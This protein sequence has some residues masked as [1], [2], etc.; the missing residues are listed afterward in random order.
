MFKTNI[1][2]V[3]QPVK[4]KVEHVQHVDSKKNGALCVGTPERRVHS[5]RIVIAEA[6]QRRF[7]SWADR[8]SRNASRFAICSPHDFPPRI[9]ACGSGFHRIA[10][11]ICSCSLAA[12]VI[13]KIP[14]YLARRLGEL[15]CS[16]CGLHFPALSEP[17]L[18]RAFADHIRHA[19]PKKEEKKPSQKAS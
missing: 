13:S 3:R 4:R 18:S 6:P 17:S 7:G 11:C 16:A 5:A 15:Y 8:T 14:P 9:G 12:I 19:H 10:A 1:A 2:M